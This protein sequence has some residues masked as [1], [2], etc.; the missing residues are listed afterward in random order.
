MV[1]VASGIITA[2][3]LREESRGAH[4]RSDFPATDA[5]LEHLHL[6]CGGSAGSIW[7]YGTLAD[8]LET[9]ST[10]AGGAVPLRQSIRG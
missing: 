7:R 6:L 9:G 3:T 1:L 10:L 5:G 4:Y 2:A 8:A